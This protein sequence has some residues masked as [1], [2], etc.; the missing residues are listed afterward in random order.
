MFNF[1]YFVNGNRAGMVKAANATEALAL[2]KAEAAAKGID[3]ETVSL[4]RG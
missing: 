1:A 3:P 4:K 2:A